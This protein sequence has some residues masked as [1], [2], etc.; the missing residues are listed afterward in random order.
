MKTVLLVDDSATILMKMIAVLKKGGY[1]VETASC[2]NDA[3]A[4]LATLKPAIIITDLNMPDMDGITLIKE[5]KKN[6]AFRFMPALLMTAE[7][8]QVRRMEARAAG[9]TGWL[10]KPAK[11][12][13]LMAILKRL[14]PG[15]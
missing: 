4:K 9:V 12:E 8:Q 3:L 5:A 13:E 15:A 10:V 6:P 7:S 14:L 2:G 11:P 1:A